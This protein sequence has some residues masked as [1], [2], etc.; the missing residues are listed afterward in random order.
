VKEIVILSGKGGTGKTTFTASLTSLAKNSIIADCDVDAPDLHLLLNPK[1]RKRNAFYSGYEAH[2]RGA[3]CDE[4][5]LCM[6][7][8]RFNA[9]N[10]DSLTLK[11]E[12][13]PVSC[14]GCGVC[15]ALCEPDAI[16][17]TESLCGEW[18][19][20]DTRYGT[21]FHAQ[22]GIG[23]EN[24]GQLVTLVRQQARQWAEQNQAD[25]LII[26]GPPGIGC[27][28]IA[29]ITGADNVV[30]VTEPT[31]SG[32]HDLE[33][34]LTLAQHFGVRCFVCINK[35]DISEQQ[36]I[37]IETLSKQFDATPV[38]RIDYDTSV[39]EAQLKHKTIVEMGQTKLSVQI[40]Q[41]WEKLQQLIEPPNCN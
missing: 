14:E 13:D 20:S 3:D 36:T 23:A 34:I 29:S 31:V 10:I 33:R 27:P 12:V 24:S 7:H 9:I 39:T 37:A 40:T 19:Q 15:V 4:C 32:L 22:L 16:D 1:I 30:V 26:D 2:I 35:W 8:C 25:F 17:F 5:G 18:F 21:L 38:G 6:K 11:P 41:I 28:A